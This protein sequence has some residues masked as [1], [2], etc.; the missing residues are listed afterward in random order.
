MASRVY[1]GHCEEQVQSCLVAAREAQKSWMRAYFL[2]LASKWTKLAR[3][4]ETQ[5]FCGAA[6]PLH[7]ACGR[8]ATSEPKAKV[9][10]AAVA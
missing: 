6:C 10:T 4:L 8:A 7:K 5:H 2:T 1:C 9:A 3:D